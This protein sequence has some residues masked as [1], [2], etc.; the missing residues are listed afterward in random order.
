MN[1]LSNLFPGG[2]PPESVEWNGDALIL[3]VR[4]PGE[5]ARG[6]VDGAL[7]LPLDG[8][9]QAYPGAGPDKSRQIIVYCQSGG[10]SGQAMRILKQQGYDNVINGGSVSA[11]AQRVKRSIVR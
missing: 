4:S 5:F 10:R 11:V 3:D 9:A 7:N 2:N 1:W 8:F 6:H